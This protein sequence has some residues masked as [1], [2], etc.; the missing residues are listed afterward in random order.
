M[1]IIETGGREQ[2]EITSILNCQLFRK[3]PIYCC[4]LV[5]TE[6]NLVHCLAVRICR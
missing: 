3:V 5:L 4:G 6:Q 2:R 1:V